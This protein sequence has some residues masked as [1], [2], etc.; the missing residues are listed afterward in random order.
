[1]KLR[2]PKPEVY[3]FWSFLVWGEVQQHFCCWDKAWGVSSI[4]SVSAARSNHALVAQ[5]LL[6]FLIRVASGN[7]T[8]GSGVSHIGRRNMWLNRRASKSRC[9]EQPVYSCFRAYVECDNA[10]LGY[11]QFCRNFSRNL[12]YLIVKRPGVRFP[13]VSVTTRTYDKGDALFSVSPVGNCSET[14]IVHDGG[15]GC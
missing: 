14:F 1:M 12:H 2:T 8:N 7:T 10:I 13:K 15:V 3:S 5:V 11:T 9:H 4:G 6:Q